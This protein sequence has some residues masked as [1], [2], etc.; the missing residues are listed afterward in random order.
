[1]SDYNKDLLP[2]NADEE[3]METPSSDKD[4]IIIDDVL[5][6]ETDHLIGVS[7][8]N[9]DLLNESQLVKVISV[10]HDEAQVWSL[11]AS[12]EEEE[13]DGEHRVPESQSQDLEIHSLVSPQPR[14]LYIGKNLWRGLSRI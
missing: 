3:P 2:L 10:S 8:S 13:S 6:K 7:Q 12:F 5:G 14:G 4:S 1:M 9:S 11:N